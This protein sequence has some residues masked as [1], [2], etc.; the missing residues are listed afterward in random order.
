[1]TKRYPVIKIEPHQ[2]DKLVAALYDRGFRYSNKGYSAG[3]IYAIKERINTYPYVWIYELHRFSV[4]ARLDMINASGCAINMNSIQQ[5]LEYVDASLTVWR[6]P[7]DA[8][9]LDN[10]G[11]DYDF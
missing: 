6:K 5:F 10:G 4:Y 1:M 3:A 11:D 8:S 9:D 2:V 7:V